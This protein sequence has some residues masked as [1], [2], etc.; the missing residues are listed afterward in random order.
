MNIWLC[1]GWLKSL[2]AMAK[3]HDLAFNCYFETKNNNNN[4]INF[5]N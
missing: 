1:E 4:K 5:E 3:L 2:E